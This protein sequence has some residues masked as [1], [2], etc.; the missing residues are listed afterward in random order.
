MN[1][2]TLAHICLS[3][4]AVLEK[5]RG[6]SSCNSSA[7]AEF[8][9]ICTWPECFS[10]IWFLIILVPL[11]HQ[12][13]FLYRLF[14]TPWEP[15]PFFSF[16]NKR[17][18]VSLYGGIC[19]W[20]WNS[21]IIYSGWRIFIL[22]TIWIKGVSIVSFSLLLFI[23]I[24]AMKAPPFH[25]QRSPVTSKSVKKKVPV[26]FAGDSHPS[27]NF[28]H[29]VLETPTPLAFITL[30]LPVSFLTPE[31]IFLGLPSQPH[32]SFELPYVTDS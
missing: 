12:W 10:S 28:A 21:L 4:P 15:T 31:T 19:G 27:N 29:S 17:K 32:V 11:Y 5:L 1:A 18:C 13:V 9:Y 22:Y 3:F 16:K 7:N 26:L 8:F 20:E 24:T 2:S 25:P 6:P 14:P 23:H 30:S